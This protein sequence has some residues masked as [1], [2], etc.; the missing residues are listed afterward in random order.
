M[1]VISRYNFV[2]QHIKVAK[3]LFKFVANNM[4]VD[5]FSF[6]AESKVPYK[7][8][9]KLYNQLVEKK[10]YFEI[11]YSP[12]IL[13]STKRRNTIY[14]SHL[15]HAFGKSKNIIVSSGAMR[16]LQIR[17]PYDVINLYPFIKIKINVNKLLDTTYT[18]LNFRNET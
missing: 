9:R 3:L 12:A 16:V 7:M 13:D 11:L 8:N 18:Y 5:I 15:Y 14:V 6:D 17:S 10:I 4:E 2:N 1:Q